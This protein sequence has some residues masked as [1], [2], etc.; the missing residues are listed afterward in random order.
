VIGAAIDDVVPGGG[1]MPDSP[2]V[3]SYSS[4]G[5][6]GSVSL[7]AAAGQTSADSRTLSWYSGAGE[8]SRRTTMPS[9][10]RWSK[11]SGAIRTHC[12]EATHFGT[13]TSTFVLVLF[14]IWCGC[15]SHPCHRLRLG[16]GRG[17]WPCEPM[18]A[19]L[20][21]MPAALH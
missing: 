19:I 11:T 6:H 3:P 13:S 17:N 1:M 18:L 7:M 9:S 16:G 5:A 14:F 12:P 21:R 10:S 15:L 20:A 4:A 8:A 2:A